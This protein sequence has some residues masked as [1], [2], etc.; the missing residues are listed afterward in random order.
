MSANSGS[1][2]ATPLRANRPYCFILAVQENSAAFM[3]DAKGLITPEFATRYLEVGSS[4]FQLKV[5]VTLGTTQLTMY[6]LLYRD[7]N[8]LVTTKLRYFDTK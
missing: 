1:Q 2:D 5:L 8:G 7:A 6:S 3:D 4:F